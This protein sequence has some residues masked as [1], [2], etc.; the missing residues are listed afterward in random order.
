[1]PR[2]R[3]MWTRPENVMVPPYKAETLPAAEQRPTRAA[4]VRHPVAE[5]GG[6]DL[7]GD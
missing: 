7:Y 3:D 6:R 2:L 1:M 4:G 5:G